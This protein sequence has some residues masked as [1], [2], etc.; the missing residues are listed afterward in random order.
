MSNE[1][2]LIISVIT[3]YSCVV[4]AYR[5]LGK[6]G[7]YSNQTL[8]NIVLSTFVIYIVTSLLDTPAVYLARK[9]ASFASKHN[10]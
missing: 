2:L 5:F 4:L 3:I 1:L 9:M 6:S 7:I 8:I 10:E